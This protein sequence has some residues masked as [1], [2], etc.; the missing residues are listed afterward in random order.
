M[1]RL[2]SVLIMLAFI[3]V[4][5]ASA[6]DSDCSAPGDFVDGI[7]FRQSSPTEGCLHLQTSAGEGFDIEVDSEDMGSAQTSTVF[8]ELV[9]DCPLRTERITEQLSAVSGSSGEPDWRVTIPVDSPDLV[10]GDWEV[11]LRGSAGGSQLT[12]PYTFTLHVVADDQNE[13]LLRA[14]NADTDT[15]I[16][17]VGEGQNV[18][19]SVDDAL[20]RQVE[21][22]LDGVG[23]LLWAPPYTLAAS[24]FQPAGQHTLKVEAEDRA[25]H[26]SELSF[27]VYADTDDPVVFGEVPDRMFLNATNHIV[28]AVSDASNVTVRA[29]IGDVVISQEG[30]AGN[31]TYTLPFIPNTLG[32]RL[33]EIT[34]EDSVGNR[35]RF[36]ESTEVVPLDAD[37]E[38]VDARQ[39]DGGAIP[40][41]DLK[42]YLEA[43]Q[44]GGVADIDVDVVFDDSVLGVMTVAA[45]GTSQQNVTFTLPIG[46][47]IGNLSLGVPA[48]VNEIDW[49]DNNRTITLE[50]F[51]ARVIHGDDIYHIRATFQG[52]PAEAVAANGTTYPLRLEDRDLR[53]V[54][55]FDVGDKKLYWDPSSTE[56]TIPEDEDKDDDN[57]IPALPLAVLLA[58]LV[59]LARRRHTR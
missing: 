28:L 40:G 16:V 2:L 31:R 42:L 36:V 7:D 54:Y 51:L 58:V 21:Y 11:S 10:T 41:E 47:H 3:Q 55:A 38:I 24:N 13:P 35:V 49:P 6:H 23:P 15:G 34:V 39:A 17:S 8:A 4:P 48:G 9:C 25:G 43:R 59:G 30:A 22:T 27:L 52:L 57:A 20:I 19:V 56:T 26:T 46:A 14:L 12:G 33:V 44:A 37:I 1:R 53:S 32:Q 18:Q 50:R 5:G 29:R 45:D